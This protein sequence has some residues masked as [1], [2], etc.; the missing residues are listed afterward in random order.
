MKTY[1]PFIL[2]A[3]AI[4]VV[5]QVEQVEP[6][7]EPVEAISKIKE[8]EV[9]TADKEPPVIEAKPVVV[10]VPF[11]IDIVGNGEITKT[12]KA[13]LTPEQQAAAWTPPARNIPDPASRPKPATP[14]EKTPEQ[15]AAEQAFANANDIGARLLELETRITEL[16]A[17]IEE[18]E[19]AK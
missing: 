10:E 4:I 3:A 1:L 13:P 16:L 15:V 2:V 8:I 14:P 5:G 6:I 11:V 9:S 17:R 19:K 12:E 18:L 7:D